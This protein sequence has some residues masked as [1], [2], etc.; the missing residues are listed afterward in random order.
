MAKRDYYEV[1]GVARDASE[2]AIK[3]AYRRLAMKHHPDRN[4]GDAAAEEKFKEASEAAEVLTDSQKRSLYDQFGHAG[5][6]G[7]ASAG[8]SAGGFSSFFEDIFGDIFSAG[9]RRRAGGGGRG[10]DLQYLLA[11]SLEE[12]V[13]GCNSQIKV[14]SLAACAECQGSGA[15]KGSSPIGCQQ[16]GGTGVITERQGFFALQQTCPRC[17]GQGK[18]IADPCARCRGQGRE[19]QERTLSV[20]VPP[21]VDTGDRIRLGGQGEAGLAGGP[22]GDLYVQIEVRPHPLFDREGANLSCDLPV[23]F[24]QAAL[25]CELKV[26]TLDGQVSLKIPP[27][28]QHGKLFRL[29][30]KGVN[31]SQVRGRGTGDLYCRILVETPVH[32][33]AK[34]KALLRSLDEESAAKNAPQQSAWRAAVKKFLGA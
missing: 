7:M 6:E 8:A 2:Q 27:E 34:Q 24:T 14:R 1:L 13:R 33:S 29:R 22:S 26:P 30:G 10:A 19:R 16:C 32:L 18:V 15:K 3:K 25:G 20:K 31:T 23:T 17:G 12:A 9:G 11:L 5:L 28:T 4:P 21:G